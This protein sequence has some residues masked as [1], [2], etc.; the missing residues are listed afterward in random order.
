MKKNY[1]TKCEVF[2]IILEE[3]KNKDD[4]KTTG[5][6]RFRFIKSFK[7][8]NKYFILIVKA[9]KQTENLQND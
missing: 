4:E 8:E 5:I 2:S 6:F 9:F 7:L 1:C 3:I